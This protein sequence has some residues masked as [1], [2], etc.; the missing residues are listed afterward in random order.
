MV[1][2]QI[3]LYESEVRNIKKADQMSAQSWYFPPHLATAKRIFGCFGLRKE[4]DQT[5]LLSLIDNKQ[6]QG[7]KLSG[8]VASDPDESSSA[9]A[10]LLS[11]AYAS[12]FL[13]ASCSRQRA[14]F[15]LRSA[16]L[17][18][19]SH[20]CL[21]SSRLSLCCSRWSASVRIGSSLTIRASQLLSH[22][23]PL[24]PEASASEAVP[25]SASCA[26]PSSPLSQ[27]LPALQEE[28][29]SRLGSPTC[30]RFWPRLPLQM[31]LRLSTGRTTIPPGLAACADGTCDN[32]QWPFPPRA[33]GTAWLISDDLFEAGGGFLT[34]RRC[35]S[36]ADTAGG[37]WS[38]VGGGRLFL[39]RIWVIAP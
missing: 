9:T 34:R 4:G 30:A 14:N 37:L 39:I 18:L 10:A 8:S 35:C 38:T 11:A 29:S 31:S 20:T 22:A 21:C 25:R 24:G 26:P 7:I 27:A 33:C 2:T 17:F 3:R 16:M 19:S 15:A 23:T 32:A 36:S 6:L 28:S 13:S 12:A 5:P 1:A